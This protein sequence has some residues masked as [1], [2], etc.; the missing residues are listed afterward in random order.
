MGDWKLTRADV[1]K[2]TKDGVLSR[3]RIDVNAIAGE[4]S[5]DLGFGIHRNRR[6]RK[7][8]SPDEVGSKACFPVCRKE[9][10]FP[11][12]ILSQNSG[13]PPPIPAMQTTNLL[14]S[15]PTPGELADLFRRH[16][17]VSPLPRIGDARWTD[18]FAQPHLAPAL[19]Q[20]MRRAHDP[21]ERDEPLPELT[22]ALYRDFSA[23]GTRIHFETV[24]FER[25]RRLARAALAL[26]A[27]PDSA[28][29]PANPLY[30]S[31]IDKLEDVFA[32]GSWALPA[33]VPDSPSG[34]DPRAIDLFGAETANLMAELLHVFGSILSGERR[35]IVVKKL[36]R[37]YFENYLAN[38]FWWMHT[39]NN[40]NAVCH[41]GV[42]GAA[43]TIEDDAERLAA[44][45]AKAAA[46]L[47]AFIDGFGDDG[48]C[49]EGPGYWG[50]GFGWF[51][52][53]NEQLET[54]TQGALS[55]FAGFP[56][57]SRIAE[58][59]PAMVLSN[60]YIVNFADCTAYAD[61]RASLLHYLGETLGS[62]ACRSEAAL[63]QTR[64]MR[65]EKLDSFCEKP[66]SDFLFYT[67]F[68]LHA[69]PALS[70]VAPGNGK[71]LMDESATAFFPSL[72]VW[73][74]RSHDARGNLWELAA[75]GGDN[76]EHHNHN[77]VGSF[78]LNL[79]GCPV[80]QEIG[81]PEYNASFFSPARYTHLA[82]RSLG[83]SLPLINGCEQKAGSEYTATILRAETAPDA[84]GRFL[85]EVDL[86]AAYPVEAGLKRFVR[87]LVFD[88]RACV[89]RW[90]DDVRL[91]ASGTMESGFITD[92]ED[93]TIENPHALVLGKVGKCIRFNVIRGGV[94][95]SD[96]PVELSWIRVD[97]H[98]C[99][100]HNGQ[101]KT[102]RRVVLAPD[103][104]ASSATHFCS[105][106]EVSL[107]GA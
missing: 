65:P 10:R 103:S 44:L 107:E 47:P 86:T 67:R 99:S 45:V 57:I 18:A 106:V 37:D 81:A 40:W 55:L 93:V 36:R 74:V 43:L 53:L 90:E 22:D 76:N 31:F 63:S 66:R 71:S 56:K 9:K 52:L 62:T 79:N 1:G 96:A 7:C 78:L 101:P 94:A 58:Y 4:P 84:S 60:G 82:A 16:A 68:V 69:P 20:I 102:W 35:S 59:G 2:H 83:H 27:A 41:Q 28:R 30:R 24:Y 72:G 46:H 80:I 29:D 64:S 26:L 25:R 21:A 17:P 11:F 73:V 92:G 61:L 23:T 87:R 91:G 54:R 105:K 14:L 98:V 50:Y 39:T 48:A 97:E 19:E 51:A 15:V 13:L 89:L 42:I 8:C 38:N 6:G 3:G 75:K 88:P 85:F 32:E 12:A 104:G 70:S 34:R 77:D 100:M 95:G 5:K 33:H 49:S